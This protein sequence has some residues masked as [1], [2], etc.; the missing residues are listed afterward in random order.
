MGES[1]F[2]Q[3]LSRTVIYESDYVCLYADRVRLP[4]G[5]IVEK[6]HQIHH[7]REA[8]GVVLFNARGEILL[9]HNRR[10]TIGREEWEIPAGRM[11]PGETPEDAARRE[12]LEECGCT[13]SDLTLLSD[14]YPA[15][16]MSD[17]VCHIFAARAEQEGSLTDTDEISGK[18]W[19]SQQQALKLLRTGETVDGHTI[20]AILWA[21]TFHRPAAPAGATSPDS[22]AAGRD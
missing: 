17:A 7:P 4:S 3:R 19:F 15:C 9:V 11:E 6:Y 2:P 13:L 10:Y 5:Q 14:H 8:V 22:P 16:G 12:C 20:L 21:L 18:Q 1:G